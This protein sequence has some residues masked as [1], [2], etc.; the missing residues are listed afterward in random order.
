MKTDVSEGTVTSGAISSQGLV[1]G[2]DGKIRHA[3]V[4]ACRAGKSVYPCIGRMDT[5]L[6][7]QVI[8]ILEVLK[9]TV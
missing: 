7:V 6:N 5:V 2:S 8:L 3:N 9:G 4:E 1:T